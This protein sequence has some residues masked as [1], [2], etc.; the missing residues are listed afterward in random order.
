MSQDKKSLLR[1]V[2]IFLL[3]CIP[4]FLLVGTGVHFKIFDYAFVPRPFRSRFEVGSDAAEH[5]VWPFVL[6]GVWILF[7]ILAFIEAYTGKNL[8]SFSKRQRKD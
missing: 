1:H 4:G 2:V 6:G 7:M 8:A 5:Q 3:T